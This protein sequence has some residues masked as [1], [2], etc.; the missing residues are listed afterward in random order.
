MA[1]PRSC[2]YGMAMFALVTP[3]MAQTPATH[4]DQTISLQSNAQI[5]TKAKAL[6]DQARSSPTGVASALLDNYPGHSVVL[7]ARAKTG[8]SEIHANWNDVMWVLDG[9]GVEVTGGTVVEAKLDTATGETRG[10]GVEG[11]TRTP[12]AKGDVLHIP[13]NTPHW[14]ILAPGKTLTLLVVKVMANGH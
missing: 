9:E 3:V 13:A 6:L 1:S 4:S 8:P 12:V 5:S 2:I 7:V 11:G 14:A 10:T